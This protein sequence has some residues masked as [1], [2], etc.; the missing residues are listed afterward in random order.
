MKSELPA[1]DGQLLSD[2]L[3]D[4]LSLQEAAR[5]QK[6]LDEDETL[7][8][9]LDDLRQLKNILR[10]APRYSIPHNFTLTPAMVGKKR[11]EILLPVLRFSS[12]AAVF[13]LVASYLLE[14]LPGGI[15]AFRTNAI[16]MAGAP[17][18]EAP[19]AANIVE[20][21]PPPII[22]WNQGGQ[23]GLPADGRGG[24]GGGPVTMDAQPSEKQLEPMFLPTSSDAAQPELAA[25]PPQAPHGGGQLLPAAPAQDAN[26]Q[27][28]PVLP[29]EMATPE[30]PSPTVSSAE[31]ETPMILGIRPTDER[32]MILSP[33]AHALEPRVSEALPYSSTAET[34]NQ[35]NNF[36]MWVKLILAAVALFS[37]I[38]ALLL[39]RKMKK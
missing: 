20:A 19:A 6:R 25:P 13:L 33:E 11:F 9:A 15:P 7:R 38:G 16:P 17:A 18:A 28:T 5:L 3:D 14:L 23:F 1:K 22:L 10:S 35:E 37:G 27:I 8:N 29:S 21:T 39:Q 32:A 36:W 4:Q 12:V 34:G 30:A 24:A 26:P 31:K 2:F